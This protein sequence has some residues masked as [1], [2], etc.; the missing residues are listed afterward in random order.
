MP[1]YLL[2]VDFQPGDDPTPL[3]EWTPAEV[4]A[5]MAYYRRL[6]D[7]LAASGELVGGEILSAPDSSYVVRSSGP[8]ATTVTEGPFPEFSEWVAGFQV[9]ETA[10]VERALEIAALVSAVPGRGG[11]PLAQPIQVR[12][13]VGDPPRDA[14]ELS[15][16]LHDA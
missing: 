15:A 9:V 6:N 13:V 10:T 3:E 8:A 5:H 14:A 2:I 7:E 4:D 11:R 16:W 1:R 12:E